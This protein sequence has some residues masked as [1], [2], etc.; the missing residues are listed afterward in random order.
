MTTEEAR[1]VIVNLCKQKSLNII[2]L[3]KNDKKFSITV[4]HVLNKKV[5]MKD[6]EELF[7]MIK[8]SVELNGVHL[9]I[10]VT[11]DT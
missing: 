11:D 1:E 9:E 10:C 3:Q 7:A 2:D 4:N 5:C 8:K 6:C